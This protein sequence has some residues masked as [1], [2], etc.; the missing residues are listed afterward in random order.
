MAVITT[1]PFEDAIFCIENGFVLDSAEHP[2]QG[3][4]KRIIIM[5]LSKEEKDILKSYEAG[6]W[7]SVH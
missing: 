1:F 4:Y 5:K 7:K 6:E 2:N 3:R